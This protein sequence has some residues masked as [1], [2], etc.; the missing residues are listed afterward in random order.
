MSRQAGFTL[1]EMLLSVT[2]IGIITGMA[3][4]VYET[5]VRR[6]DLDLAAQNLVGALRRAET[7]SRAS[8]YNSGWSVEIQSSAV[9]LFRGNSFL[10]RN[11]AYDESFTLP[12]TVTWSGLGEV[13]FT[14]LSG[15]PNITGTVTLTSN[16][17]DNRVITI[18]SKG[19]IDY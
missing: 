15:A 16:A 14:E 10:L 19:M 13:Q 1:V 6:N 17:N 11:T 9:T 12:G 5:F 18:N 8:N 7:Y 4:P 2:I 3:L